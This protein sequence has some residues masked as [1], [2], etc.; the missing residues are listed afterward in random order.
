MG[1]GNLNKSEAF[2]SG[3]LE[4]ISCTILAGNHYAAVL[5]EYETDKDR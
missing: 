3:G 5:V 1:G 4:D 2:Q